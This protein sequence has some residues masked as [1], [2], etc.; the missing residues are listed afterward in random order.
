MPTV[1]IEIVPEQEEDIVLRCRAV[2][3]QILRLQEALEKGGAA[4]WEMLVTLGGVEYILP[5]DDILFFESRDEKT[6][7]HTKT[8]MYYTE[9]TLAKLSQIIPGEFFRGSKSCIVNVRKI[10][11]LKRELT[12]VCEARFSGCDKNVFISRM[13]YKAFREKLDEVRLGS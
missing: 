8:R 9:E 5:Y 6:A 7:V 3:P 13:Y 10:S 1:R 4:H 11:S 12:G 2:T